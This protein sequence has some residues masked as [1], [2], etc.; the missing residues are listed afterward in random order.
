MTFI[1][2]DDGILYEK[3]LGKNTAAAAKSIKEYDPGR[4]WHKVE[5]EPQETATDSTK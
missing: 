4:G 1:I 5:N 3:D 2:G